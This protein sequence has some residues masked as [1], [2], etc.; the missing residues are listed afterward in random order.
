MQTR[1]AH[2]ALH[3]AL[4]TFLSREIHSAR[5]N[6]AGSVRDGKESN[7]INKLLGAAAMAAM[8]YP[9]VPAAAANVAGCSGANLE[10]T[11]LAVEGMAD[12]TGKFVAQRE[13][14]QAQDALLNGKGGACAMHLSRAMRGGSVAQAPYQAP[15]GGSMA[16]APAETTYQAPNQPQWNWQPMKAAQ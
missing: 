16:Q 5:L 12:G 6:A 10:K 14:A 11:G 9:T 2:E 3:C 4:I 1:H 8:I 7:M 15:Y 13:V